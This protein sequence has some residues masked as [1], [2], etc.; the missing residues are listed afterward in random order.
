MASEKVGTINTYLGLQGGDSKSSSATPL[1]TIQERM[2][3]LSVLNGNPN[4]LPFNSLESIVSSTL[5]SDALR[6]LISDLSK[7]E[8]V[9][10]DPTDDPFNPLVKIAE[11]GTEQLSIWF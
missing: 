4:G 1:P 3:V 11:K 2:L 5:P 8:L 9:T 6:T 10:A 7:K